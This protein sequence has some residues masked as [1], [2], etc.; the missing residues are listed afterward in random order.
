MP[1]ALFLAILVSTSQTSSAATE[2]TAVPTPSAKSDVQKNKS[3][4]DDDWAFNSGLYT[5][6]PQTG[7]RTWQYAK[8]KPAYR[9]APGKYSIEPRYYS[10]DPFFLP[11][12]DEMFFLNT[13][14]PFYAEPYSELPGYPSANDEDLSDD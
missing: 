14:D 4:E 5:D 3:D 10:G 7:Q 12:T 9:D 8:E 2:S 13:P 11:N 1:F 6:N